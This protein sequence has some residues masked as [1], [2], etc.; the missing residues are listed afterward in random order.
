MSIQL[1]R[2]LAI[3]LL[4]SLAI[5]LA[6]APPSSANPDSLHR[7]DH[8][9][10][11]RMLKIRAPFPP[12]PRQNPP[13]GHAGAVG[14]AANPTTDGLSSSSPSST[15]VAAAPSQPSSASPAPQPTSSL[16]SPVSSP[17]VSC[18]PFT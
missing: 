14:G 11:N 5:L 7:R 4:F 13:D 1:H 18:F 16:P 15:P 12:V 3:T 8:V 6:L 10:L 2:N 9:N 17:A